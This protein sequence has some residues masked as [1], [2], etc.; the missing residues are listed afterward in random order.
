M[1]NVSTEKEL[2]KARQMLVTYAV[3][4]NVNDE[5]F[6][7]ISRIVTDLEKEIARRVRGE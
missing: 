4:E 2:S 6:K 3:R 1:E 7:I 5:T